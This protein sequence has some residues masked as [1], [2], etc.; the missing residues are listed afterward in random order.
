VADK[1]GLFSRW[2]QVEGVWEWVAKSVFAPERDEV[3][4][5]WERSTPQRAV[6]YVVLHNCRKITPSL[7]DRYKYTLGREGKTAKR[8]HILRD[9]PVLPC[10]L[11]DVKLSR[12]GCRSST[13]GL[14]RMP[15][16]LAFYSSF[17]SSITMKCSS[18]CIKMPPVLSKLKGKKTMS[19][20]I[21]RMLRQTIW[22]LASSCPHHL[23]SVLFYDTAQAGS[24]FPAIIR[25]ILLRC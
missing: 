12:L 23:P 15:A 13:Y 4:K 7:D 17:V 8:K 16:L 18:Q 22:R 3:T 10:K 2:K 19:S 9:N 24:Y 1:L 11:S 21:V 20:L 6:P 14:R 5:D 25:L